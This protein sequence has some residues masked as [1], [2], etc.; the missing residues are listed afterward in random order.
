MKSPKF[1]IWIVGSETHL[2][3]FFAKV[4]FARSLV[5]VVVK[6][7]IRQT[8]NITSIFSLNLLYRVQW[9]VSKS[10]KAILKIV[11]LP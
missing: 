6:F 2:T 9:I 5:V 3:V 8:G 4:C 1:P 7:D 10:K 11:L